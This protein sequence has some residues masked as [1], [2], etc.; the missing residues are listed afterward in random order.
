MPLVVAVL[1]L[2]CGAMAAG[3]EAP[4]A[5]PLPDLRALRAGLRKSL[6]TAA[7]PEMKAHREALAA[8]E[9]KLA[10]AQD[11]A[12]AIKARDEGIKLG[13]QVA[14]LEQEAAILATRTSVDNAAR[15][16]ARIELNLADARLAGAQWDAKDGAITGW[17]QQDAS[18]TWQLSGLPP[19]G[20]EVLLRC[21]GPG[22][23]VVVK[24]DFYSLSG[25]CPTTADKSSEQNLGTLR[26]RS[27]SGSFTLT[28][29]QPD[30]RAAWRVYGVVLVPSDL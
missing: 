21:T 6:L 5:E 10:A 17:E 24:E 25:A 16:A 23:D 4:A 9:Q 2:A 13:K 29:G 19:G 7:L 11:F 27:G 20:Y 18:A 30:K 28:A 3:P 22:G 1:A 14:E 15:L 12:G 26:I 8:L